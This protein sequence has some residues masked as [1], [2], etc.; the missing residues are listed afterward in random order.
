MDYDSYL[1]N[2]QSECDKAYRIANEARSK[3]LDP[4]PYVEIPQAHDLAD[5]TQ[6]LLDFLH[7]RNTAEQIRELT[8]KLEGNR[9]LV[10]LEIGKIVSA[11]TYLYGISKNCE[12]CNGKGY[13]KKGEWKTEDCFACG[14]KG[15]KYR[16]KEMPH[17]EKTLEEFAKLQEFTNKKQ[18]EDSIYHGV[19]AGLAVLTEGILVA[20]LEGV[21]SARILDNSDGSNCIAIS[22]AGPIRSA[23]GTGQ[24]L[25]V[26]IGDILRR[27]FKISLPIMTSE[28]VERYK[29]EVGAYARGLQY[30][31][32]NP[33]LEII[34]KKCPVYL[35]GEGVGAEVSGQR[36]LP[37]VPTNKVREG[38]ILVMCEGL[39]LKAPKILKYVEALE[40]DG[41]EWLKSFVSDKKDTT[42]GEGVEPNYKYLGDVL[43]GRPVFSQP[44]EKGGFR[45]RYGRSRL[46]GLATTS[47]H[48]ATMKV[49]NSF[50]IIGTQIKYERP[51]KA[52]VLTPCTDIDAPY[53]QFKDGS[54][55]R[56]K[57][58]DDIEEGLAT[59]SDWKIEKV[60]DLG[61]LLVPVGEFIENNHPIIPSAFNEDYYEVL[62]KSKKLDIPTTFMESIR[63]CRANN[64][65]LNPKFVPFLNDISA[66]KLIY[67]INSM[68]ISLCNSSVKVNSSVLEVVYQLCIDVENIDGDYHLMGDKSLILLN[69]YKLLKQYRGDLEDKTGLELINEVLDY[70]VKPSVSYR[71]GARMGKPEGA[72]L[73]EMKP[74]IHSLFPV[75]FNVGS[76]RKVMD[77]VSMNEAVHIG[78][79]ED[80]EGNETI[81]GVVD[82]DETKFIDVEKRTLDWG[83]LWRDAKLVAKAVNNPPIKGVKGMT[84]AEKIPENLAKGILRFEND[85]SVFRD[86]TIRFDF[87]DITMT[88]FKP[89]EIG[90][91]AEKARE[92]GYD[93]NDG[94]DIV[95]LKPQDIVISSLVADKFLKT[96]KF[97]D[98]MLVNLYGLEP[99]YKAEKIE[100][101]FGHLMMG[102]APHT[103]GAILCRLIGI[104]DVKGHYGHPYFHAAK[105]RNCDGDIDCVLMLLDGLINFSKKFLATTRGGKM[106]APLILTTKIVPSE[107]DKEALNVDINWEYPIEFY[108]ASQNFIQAKDV[109]K[110]GIITVESLL[111]TGNEMEGFGYTHKTNDC[112][113]AP[114]DNPYTTLESMRQKTMAQFELGETLVAVDNKDQSSRLINRH[115][116]RDMRG[117]LRAYGQQK[118]RCVKCG[119]SYR[120]PPLTGECS[121]II[122]ERIDSFSGKPIVVKCPGK[123]ILTVS[124]GSVMKYEPLM[125][126]LVDR[127]GCSTYIGETH[128]LVS[129]WVSQS[130]DE[131]GE[132]KQK[133]L[134]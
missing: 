26:L 103:S 69:A 104:A 134:F 67:L 51:G 124:K 11:E 2:L 112:S 24:A 100:D 76:Q 80:S 52:T 9:E 42:E 6:K 59:D 122:E 12:V 121:T 13:I 28:E 25:S 77:L 84:S 8:V 18:I 131:D 71:I 22:F 111:G 41:W 91:T 16:Y 78:I 15:R 27:M 127:Y 37:R 36:D 126:E 54:A 63:L 56:I 119:T 10:A 115:L 102:L 79:R 74:A 34:A 72:K 62:L 118:V 58:T 130:F 46:A 50:I 123:V 35:D 128:R 89:N 44:M 99:F 83:K 116:I 20:P 117:N 57:T 7:S 110:Y 114:L 75:G 105:R 38:S 40:L 129:Y 55:R 64:I 107:I 39:V 29:E 19:C 31:P 33:Q 132:K 87:V 133:S 21:V 106:D 95:E 90:L 94:E 65:P 66:E 70:E 98:S 101:L 85:I 113:E 17:Y 49:L 43:A 86:G 93:V 4:V 96:S 30:R 32:S 92:L 48:P 97:I 5:R 108:E 60:W 14:M 82:G 120:R 61:E 45:L 23:G 47:I 125:N 68:N 3:G 88:H 53:V 81:K 1:K 109:H 73:R